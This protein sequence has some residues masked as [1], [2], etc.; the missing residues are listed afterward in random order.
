QSLEKIISNQMEH[1][2]FPIRLKSLGA[3]ISFKELNIGQFSE[4]IDGVIVE[5]IMNNHPVIDMSY[6]FTFKSTGKSIA[7][8]TDFELYNQ[9]YMDAVKKSKKININKI[10]EKLYCDLFDSLSEFVS[11]CDLLIMDSV[12]LKEEYPSKIGWGHSCFED[13]YNLA[14]ESNVKNLCFFHHEPNRKDSELLSIENK[15]KKINKNRGKLK[16]VFAA[17]EGMELLL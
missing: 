13:V 17:A 9:A 14:V 16:S 12:Y 7:Y 10:G 1:S 3:N 2:Y 11:E 8:V 15:F 5:T 4:L 6:K